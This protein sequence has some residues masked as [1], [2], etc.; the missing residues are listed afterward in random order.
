VV[1]AAAAELAQL[2]ALLFTQQALNFGSASRHVWRRKSRPALGRQ[3]DPFAA[4]QPAPAPRLIIRFSRSMQQEGAAHHKGDDGQ[5]QGDEQQASQRRPPAILK[6]LNCRH[7]TATSAVEPIQQIAMSN[8][9][10]CGA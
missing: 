9:A 5:Q 7:D 2:L 8:T 3:L 1:Q 6:G 4:R 10:A